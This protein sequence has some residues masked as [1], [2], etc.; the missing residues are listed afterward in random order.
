MAAE[1]KRGSDLGRPAIDWQEAFVYYASLPADKRNY[2]AVATH[3]RISVRTVETP[4]LRE[5][6][7]ERA[8]QVDR[9]AAAAAMEQLAK[10][11]ART[12]ADVEKLIDA[13]E[14][15]YAQNLR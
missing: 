14:V 3:Y 4:G 10:D 15:T 6:W 2:R 7:K 12:L 8:R 9:E 5:R 13:S 1:R 11:R